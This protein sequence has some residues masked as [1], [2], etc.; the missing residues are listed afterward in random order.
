MI[1]W[2]IIGVL[3]ILLVFGLIRGARTWN[4]VPIVT[5]V[6]IFITAVFG[7]YLASQVYK[8]RG[9]WI[10][11]DEV[12]Q[13]L[14]E[15]ADREFNEVLY[16]PAN[17][18]EYGD[19]SL[20][21]TNAELDIL[22]TGQGRVWQGAQP[23]VA[24]DA[25]TL[26]FPAAS[27]GL[28]DASQIR[29]DMQVYAF[30][31]QSIDVDGETLTAPVRF[32]GTFQVQSVDAAANSVTLKPLFVTNTSAGEVATPTTTWTLF[33][34]MPA[35]SRSVFLD[36]ME[37]SPEDG[38]SDGRD[39]DAYREALRS[40]FL[41]AD[42]VGLDP[43]SREYEALL[44]QYSFDGLSLNVIQQWIDSAPNR[45]SELFDPE[46]AFRDVLLRFTGQSD[47]ITVDGTANAV[48]EGIFDPQGRANDPSLH[49]NR[50]VTISQ[51]EEV[52][53][54]K[55]TGD[56]FEAETIVDYYRRPL[57][58][59]PF[60]LQ[61]MGNLAARLRR[62]IEDTKEDIAVSEQMIADTNAQIQHRNELI[63]KLQSDI[64]NRT[65]EMAALNAHF[66]KLETQ[67]GESEAAIKLYYE[68]ILELRR[69]IEEGTG[70]ASDTSTDVDRTDGRL[71]TL[72]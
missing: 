68:Q 23:S 49:L 43:E 17:A 26:T 16:G 65:A 11:R 53:I 71:L 31:E 69:A 24:A 36:A 44:D 39:I 38:A 47:P 9:A 41:P 13:E 58:D 66:D 51:D 30:A 10:Y 62:A 2:I 46:D 22:M 57:R 67:L 12:N 48:N 19:E 7:L 5:L 8:A 72:R 37:T 64:S 6:L 28:S 18:I 27:P 52:L 59:Y 29:Q 20:L 54:P 56:D 40:R 25:I 42:L 14:A 34:T 60:A 35:D 21:G 61:E 33:E 45:I 55:D 4:W 50:D 3:L 32:L 1:P 15:D 63:A 70:A